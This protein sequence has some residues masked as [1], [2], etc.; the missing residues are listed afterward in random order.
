[1]HADVAEGW[2]NAERWPRPQ[3]NYYHWVAEGLSRLLLSLRLM[4]Q[5]KQRKLLVPQGIAHG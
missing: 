5:D 1:M 3:V 4:E 2:L